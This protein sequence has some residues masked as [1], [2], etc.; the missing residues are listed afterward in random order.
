MVIHLFRLPEQGR[1]I[2]A[3]DFI[4]R[5]KTLPRGNIFP[6]TEAQPRPPLRLPDS[7]QQVTAWN[8][9]RGTGRGRKAL[10]PA[11]KQAGIELVDGL[12]VRV[13]VKSWEQVERLLT[14]LEALVRGH[15][16]ERPCNSARFRVI[17]T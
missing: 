2:A 6:K 14:E 8:N 1:M 11:G 7:G 12:R 15:P 16:P 5:L 3:A 17:R 9:R 13:T 10:C 4:G